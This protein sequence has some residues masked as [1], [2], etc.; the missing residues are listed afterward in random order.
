MITYQGD[1]SAWDA[2]PDGSAVAIGVFDGVHL[3]HRQVLESLGDVDP[4]LTRVAMTFGTHPASLLSPDGA[5]SRLSTLKRRFDLFE[6]AGIDRIAVLGFDEEMRTMTPEDFVRRFLVEGLNARFVVVG[7][8]FRFGQGAVGTTEMLIDLGRRYG[9][10]VEVIDIACNDGTEIRSTTIR[11]ALIGGDVERAAMMLGRPYDLEGIVV[12]G[13]GRGR[14]IGVATANVSF[15]AVLT[16]PRHGVYAVMAVV[17]GV[18]H[19]A[20]ANLGIRPT[21]GGEDEVLEVHILGFDRDLYG[22]HLRIEFVARIRDEIR[23]DSVDDLLI[24]IHDD[25]VSASERLVDHTS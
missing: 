25:M 8:G 16:V 22:R 1:P 24:Q 14:Q 3:G 10:E 6:E 2:P 5:P 13:D 20:V 17:D 15:P 12:A 21:F 19:P 23:F 18:G 9:F 11:D 4:S 7:V